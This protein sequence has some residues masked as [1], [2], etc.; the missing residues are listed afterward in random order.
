MKGGGR[1]GKITSISCGS[2]PRLMIIVR[3]VCQVSG[4]G[5]VIPRVTRRVYVRPECAISRRSLVINVKVTNGT[6]TFTYLY[7]PILLLLQD[8]PHPAHLTNRLFNSSH[9]MDPA[10]PAEWRETPPGLTLLRE[11]ERRKQ[12]SNFR[13]SP[14]PMLIRGSSSATSSQKRDWNPTQGLP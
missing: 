11:E 1:F 3:R 5:Q 7:V 13:S 14:D 4:P 10:F 12:F 6:S 9:W 8:Q 2:N